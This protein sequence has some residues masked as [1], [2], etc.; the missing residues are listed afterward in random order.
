MLIAKIQIQTVPKR[1][2]LG[3]L[4]YKE[5]RCI[6]VWCHHLYQGTLIFVVNE[7]TLD[8]MGVNLD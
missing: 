1:C 3:I 2:F 4:Q 8:S 5:G 6:L 7:V